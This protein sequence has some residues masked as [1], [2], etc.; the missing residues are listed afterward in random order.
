MHVCREGGGAEEEGERE[1]CMCQAHYS[2]HFTHV[3]GLI[4]KT[5]W[6]ERN[7]YYLSFL[8]ALTEP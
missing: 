6:R 7:Y 3:I 1:S 5:A 2:K 8:V 4:L